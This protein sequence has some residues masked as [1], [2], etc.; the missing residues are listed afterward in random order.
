MVAV[1]VGRVA[2]PRVVLVCATAPPLPIQLVALQCMGFM[3][4][5]VAEV[6]ETFEGDVPEL[7]VDFVDK[8]LTTIVKKRSFFSWRTRKDYGAWI[9][10]TRI[11]LSNGIAWHRLT[12]LQLMICLCK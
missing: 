7:P 1:R 6:E 11:Q 8:M 3:C 5:R 9:V 2:L 10:L 12:L 4:E